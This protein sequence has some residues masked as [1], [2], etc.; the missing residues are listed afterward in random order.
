MEQDAVVKA[1]LGQARDPIDMAGSQ[2]RPQLDDDVAAGRKGKG[3]RI[4][5]SHCH[6]LGLENLAAI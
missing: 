1:V 4:G 3:K 5:I 6:V 2:V